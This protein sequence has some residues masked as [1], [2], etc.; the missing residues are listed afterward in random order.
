[1]LFKE[2]RIELRQGSL[3]RK[4]PAPIEPP[5]WGRVEGMLLGL[6]IGDA[7]GNTSEG[8][9][10]RERFGRYG[11]IR[12]YLPNSYAGGRP[13]GLPSDDTQLAFWT[14]QQ[15][16]EDDGLV[17]E[18]LGHRF[19]S[20]QIFGIGATVR[21]FVG[22]LRSG[23]G[24]SEAGQQSAGNGALMRIAPVLISHVKWKL[25]RSA[26]RIVDSPEI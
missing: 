18:R 22:A 17:P 21:R 16:V 20:G 19:A 10:P 8:M 6:A 15:L 7:L 4:E 24:W 9:R 5:Y 3:F 2:Q 13:V 14:L 25:P 26:R 11:E 12:D 23:S 1:M